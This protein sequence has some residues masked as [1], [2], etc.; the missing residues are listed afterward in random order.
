MA[1]EIQRYSPEYF[2]SLV[3]LL[4]ESF[5]IANPARSDLVRWKF[6]DTIHRGG[7]VMALAVAVGTVVSQYANTPVTL[8]YDGLPFPAMV[9]ADMATAPAYRGQGLISRLAREVYAEVV[10]SGAALSIGFSNEEGLK[11][12]RNAKG[13][14]YRVIGRFE[15]YLLP[16][17][18]LQRTDVVLEPAS[19]FD[20]YHLRDL[21]VAGLR[22]DKSAE[23][24]TWR[25]LRKPHADYAIYRVLRD[26]Q[27]LGYAVLRDA[28]L[29]THLVDLIA[30]AVPDVLTAV[31]NAALWRRR[32]R[33]LMAYVLDNAAWRAALRGWLHLPPHPRLA[34]YYLT[35]RPHC[36]PLPNGWETP[37]GWHLMGGDII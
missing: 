3:R 23:Y 19:E 33:A 34:N 31:Q 32:K 1:V 36:E 29:R 8:A 4:D 22:L 28:R 10:R 14:G 7:T 9:C 37:D 26:R 17:I 12:D 27:P 21:P 25:Y 5:G 6:F 16:L 18:R 24:L 35:V 2:A 11:V 15:R 30:P 20:S 13:Y